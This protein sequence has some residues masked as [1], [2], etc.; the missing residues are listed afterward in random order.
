MC[1]KAG[2]DERARKDELLLAQGKGYVG[3]R[4]VYVASGM[5]SVSVTGDGRGCVKRYSYM[6]GAVDVSL[7]NG[8]CARVKRRTSA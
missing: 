7:D 8:I 4:E 5:L 2:F 1:E 3:T 6:Q